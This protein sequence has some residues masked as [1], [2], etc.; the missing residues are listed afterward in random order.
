MAICWWNIELL[1]FE[2]IRSANNVDT[3]DSFGENIL[4]VFD[5]QVS[6]ISHILLGVFADNTDT[7]ATTA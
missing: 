6:V 1:C 5:R 7:L 2:L 3:L 4:Y